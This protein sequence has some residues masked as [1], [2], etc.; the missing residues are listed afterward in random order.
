[1]STFSYRDAVKIMGASEHRAVAVLDKALGGGL[2][3]GTAMGALDLLGWFDAK[4]DF[5]RLSHE[6][7]VRWSERRSGIS[8]HDRTQRLHAAHTMIV[9]ASFF[10]ALDE[11]GVPTST[12]D[13]GLKPDGILPKVPAELLGLASA[14]VPLVTPDRPYEANLTALSEYYAGLATGLRS[15]LTGLAV[16]DDMDDRQRGLLDTLHDLACRRYE[17]NIRR[18]A[19]DCPEFAFWSSSQDHQATRVVVRTAL[20]EVER[21]FATVTVGSPSAVRRTELTARYRSVLDQGI[22]KPDQ[23]PDGLTIPLVRDCYVDPRFQ[24]GR[25]EHPARTGSWEDVPVRDDVHDFLI[26][27]LTSPLATRSPLLVLGDPGSGKSVLTKVLAARLPSTDFLPLRVE[28]RTAPTEAELL[29]QIEH[30]LWLALHETVSWA[31]FA[32]SADGAL[33]VVIL[34]GFDEL[35]QAT[36][37]SQTGYLKKVERFQRENAELGRPVAV[38][39]TSRISV[40]DRADLPDDAV[41]M[42]L[43]PFDPDQT[44][45]WVRA[46]NDTNHRYFSTALKPLPLSAVLAYPDLAEQPLLLLMLAL[47]DADRNALQNST[48]SISEADLYERLLRRFAAR[49][50]EKDGEDRSEGQLAEEVEG[51][52]E[53]LSLVAFAMFNR[54]AQWIKEHELD[55]DMAAL[56]G[57]V[58]QKDGVREPLGAGEAVL[59]RF[60]FIQRAEATRDA[61][62]LRTYEFLHA[63]F[64][65]YLVA[66][67]TWHTLRGLL[68][69]ERSAPRLSRGRAL[70]DSTLHSLLSFAPLTTRQPVVRFL[71]EMADTD[72]DRPHLAKMLIRVF[73]DSDRHREKSD[74]EPVALPV[75]SRYAMYSV[76]VMVM[77]VITSGELDVGELLRPIAIGWRRHALFWKSKIVDTAWGQLIDTIQLSKVVRDGKK[78]LLLHMKDSSSDTPLPDLDWHFRHRVDESAFGLARIRDSRFLFDTEADLDRNSLAP[79][80]EGDVTWLVQVGGATFTTTHAVLRLLLGDHEDPERELLWNA[81]AR[82]RFPQSANIPRLLARILRPDP[83]I[84][85]V[86]PVLFDRLP[87]DDAIDLLFDRLGKSD[88]ITPPILEFPADF[89]AQVPAFDAVL[90]MCERGEELHELTVRQ[91]VHIVDLPRLAAARPDLVKR[92]RY[93]AQEQGWSDEVDWP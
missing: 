61:K 29:Q 10:E 18:L 11:S 81:L 59:G 40:A 71:T 13:L 38:V 58:P 24:V 41:V 44:G 67:L 60:F 62:T 82:G 78:E 8:R 15:F 65:E 17:E 77:A 5:V 42:R 52:L 86:L 46:W 14:P 72:P 70:D 93:A 53:R 64:S 43:A 4:A 9:L 66:R 80:N 87:Y 83:E 25:P 51:E 75:T 48:D 55:R 56:L 92:A 57:G 88:G 27:H 19:T 20:A 73:Q 31:A 84:D 47:Y 63:T 90:R 69:V 49:E 91:S 74:Y 33:P 2:L 34:D 37:V 89:E 36:G 85:R 45:Q 28:L 1:M 35:L 39:V 26:G 3:A 7:A 6:Y 32:R 54:G 76:N 23:V 12:E 16:W 30:G 21:L 22:I 79:M 50:V 68:A